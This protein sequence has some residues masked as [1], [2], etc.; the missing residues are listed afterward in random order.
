M[1]TISASPAVRA[2]PYWWEAA[3]RPEVPEVSPPAR[4]DV[5]IVGSGYTGL[6]AALGLARRGRTVVVLDAQD[7]GYGAS[8]RNGGVIGSRMKVSFSRMARERGHDFA[9]AIYSDTRRAFEF[10]VDLIKR[11]K[12]DCGL[13]ESGRFMGARQ[14]GDYD[15]LARDAEA[16]EKHLGVASE[17][18][19]KSEV[20]REVGTDLYHGGVLRKLFAGVHPGL[21]HHGLLERARD[22]GVQL[23]AFTPATGIVRDNG[24]YTV[25][26]SRGTVVA[27]DVVVATNGYTGKVTPHLRRRVIPIESQIFVTEPLGK[28]RMDQLMPTRRLMGDTSRL[29]HYFRPTPDGDRVLFGGRAGEGHLYSEMVRIFPEMRGVELSHSWRGNVAYTFDTMPHIGVHDGMHFAMG[30]CGSGLSMGTYF[31]HKVAQRI[32]GGNDTVTAFDD[33]PFQTRPL[34]TGRPWF[35]P[36]MLFFYG[37]RDRLGL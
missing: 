33:I 2:Y 35:M 9:T 15:N 21:F 20:H 11:E 18:I 1:D 26:T 8:T 10:A 16:M 4:A 22:A 23:F 32:L 28:A 5:V 14:P 37:L 3:P 29:H 7:L 17:V 13:S 27:R 19:P 30:Y 31:G 12:I 25:T 34:Y 36:F 24:G 6:V